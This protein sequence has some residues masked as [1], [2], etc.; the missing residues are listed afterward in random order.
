MTAAA[1]LGGCASSGVDQQR[2]VL[3]DGSVVMVTRFKDE[4]PWGTD[5]TVALVSKCRPPCDDDCPARC[6][7]ITVGQ[8]F[9]KGLGRDVLN[10]VAPA[11]V[12]G[13]FYAL[14]QS[15]RRPDEVNVTA[16]GGSAAGGN[17]T[18]SSVAGASARSSARARSASGAHASSSSKQMQ[19]SHGKTAKP[20]AHHTPPHAHPPKPHKPP[21]PKHPQKPTP[22]QHQ[23][24]GKG[25]H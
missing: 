13:G 22:K 16:T 8:S 20:P 17:A 12:E 23:H 19:G 7:D 14:G 18:S 21:P 24:G 10:N 11:V 1:M 2:A 3:P 5:S 15:L 9:Q 4:N 6:K 25:H